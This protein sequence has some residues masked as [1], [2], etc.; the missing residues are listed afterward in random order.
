MSQDTEMPN[1][2]EPLLAHPNALDPHV[3]IGE[4]NEAI[5]IYFGP[6]T[7]SQSG[8]KFDAEA[9]IFLKWLP[10]PTLALEIPRI[11]NGSLPLHGDFTATIEN[12]EGIISGTV[13][14]IRHHVDIHNGD[15]TIFGFSGSIEKNL[16]SPGKAMAKYATF[17]I[18]NFT[19]PMGRCALY[20]G[21]QITAGRLGLKGGGWS[22][23]SDMIRDY[24]Q[25][26][27]HIK[28]NSGYAITQVGRIEREDN[29]PFSAEDAKIA[30]DALGWY[31]AFAA[32]RWT[33]PCLTTGFA[34][35]GERSWEDWD[36]RR[37]AAYR[38]RTSWLDPI[39]GDQFEAP[40]AGFMKMWMD[41]TW[42]DTIRLAIH[43]YVEA[44]SLA[45][46]IEGSIVLTQTAFELLA[47]AVLT[48]HYGW[49]NQDTFDKI[50]AADRIRLLFL[51]AG[52]PTKIPDELKGLITLAKSFEDFMINK[53]P[54]SA[55]S[56]TA[57]RNTI[58]HPT[59][60]NRLKFF[61]QHSA[62]ARYDCYVLGLRNLELLL[63]KLFEH[64][65][66]YSLANSRG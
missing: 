62:E 50:A 1:T 2:P 3:A 18:P 33:G 35:G 42:R 63:L 17:L 53:I 4:P 10:S 61:K 37:V 56:M 34:E 6:V 55:S 41:D 19:Q 23:T 43:W 46:S 15:M 52:I 25:V 22:I 44:N 28:A 38:G 12:I 5:R 58:T 45:G 21:G 59:S 47:S 8:K 36:L 13:T 54:D 66:T 30:V 31:I 16:G 29:R 57:I 14:R 32:G 51:W 9:I 39:H 48:E 65:G 7:F 27:I 20:P 24:H 26:E 40:F 49:L 11:P 64:S 60:K